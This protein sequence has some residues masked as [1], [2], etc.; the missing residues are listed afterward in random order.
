MIGLKRGTVEL[1]PYQE[2]WQRSA[3]EVMSELKE[4]LGNTAIAIQHIGSTAIRS[5]HAKPIIDIAVGVEK[6]EDIQPYIPTLEQHDFIYRGQDVAGQILFV[7]TGIEKDIRTHYIHIVEWK[8]TAWNNYIN[9]RDYLNTFE[10]KAALYDRCKQS[11]AAQFPTDRGKYTAGKQ[12]LID[13]LLK[14]ASFWKAQSVSNP[15]QDK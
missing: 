5:I 13:Q 15:D 7:L 3:M 8:G 14:E 10:E 2:D 11:L 4:I 12:K 6:L 1:V 9:F